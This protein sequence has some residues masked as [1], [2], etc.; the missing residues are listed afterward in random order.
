MVGYQVVGVGHKTHLDGQLWPIWVICSIQHC[1]CYT[2]VCVS[3]PLENVRLRNAVMLHLSFWTDF[4]STKF[5]KNAQSRL[6][7]QSQWHLGPTCRPLSH[8]SLQIGLSRSTVA[9]TTSAQKWCAIVLPNRAMNQQS[10]NSLP[11]DIHF[12]MTL[13]M[14]DLASGG[15]T[16]IVALRFLLYLHSESKGA[17]Q[18]QCYHVARSPHLT[19]SAE[20]VGVIG[21]DSSHN[22]YV[23]Y[24]NYM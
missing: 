10:H 12:T 11:P 1:R 22:L 17:L 4:G 14:H 2:V 5:I 16:V 15:L 6:M 24:A 7:S 13:R 18:C 20:S 3:K 19:F 8:T 23:L 21:S 9:V